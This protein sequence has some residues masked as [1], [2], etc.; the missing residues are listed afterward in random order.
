MIDKDKILFLSLLLAGS[1]LMPVRAAGSGNADERV[2]IRLIEP[3][4]GTVVRSGEMKFAWEIKTDDG[5]PIRVTRYEVTFWAERQSFNRTFTVVPDSGDPGGVFSLTDSR[6]VFR[7]HGQYY[8]RIIA[9][10]AAGIPVQSESRDFMVLVSHESVGYT[11][12]IY[13]YA[14]EMRFTQRLR[15]GQ[16]LQFIESLQS[17]SQFTDYGSLAF[18]FH[19]ERILG[20]TLELEERFLLLSQIGVGIEGGPRFRLIRNLFFS[21]YPK[22]SVSS[23]W[24]STGLKNYSTN[25]FSWKAGVELAFNPR[26]NIIIAWNWMPEYRIR[27][28]LQGGDLRTFKGKGWEAGIRIKIPETMIPPFSVAGMEID[29]RRIP[30]EFTVSEIID[31]YTNVTMKM[32]SIGVVFLFW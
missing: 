11:Q 16:Y 3:R 2:W 13:P 20:T 15:S 23:M 10:D 31:E 25:L 32:R 30:I 5:E 19:Q 28:A 24:F 7:R 18:I 8:W 9:Y 22:A 26:E 4:S 27:Y 14:I 17:S 12:W 6:D 29:L 21:L 1:A